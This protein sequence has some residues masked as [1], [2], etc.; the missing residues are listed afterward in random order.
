VSAAAEAFRAGGTPAGAE[1][2]APVARGGRDRGRRG[3]GSSSF[4]PRTDGP[5]ARSRSR[6][7]PR[8]RRSSATSP[9]SFATRAGSRSRPRT[10]PRTSSP[11]GTR[12]E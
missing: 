6:T 4:R 8:R 3:G 5:A 2:A 1:A 7:S 10:T 11:R 9:A 12:W